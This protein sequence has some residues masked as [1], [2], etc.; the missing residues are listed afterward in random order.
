[1]VKEE[2]PGRSN[3]SQPIA[4]VLG[5]ALNGIYEFSH[6]IAVAH[7]VM[8]LNGKRHVCLSVLFQIASNCKNGREVC[9]LAVNIQIEAGEAVPGEGGNSEK[10]FRHVVLRK[11]RIRVAVFFRIVNAVIIK[12]AEIT[13][14]WREYAAERF[15]LLV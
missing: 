3:R 4:E 13:I 6:M 1:M 10:I 9:S 7:C 14:K 12:L 5:Q 11:K 2:M 15:S 8:H